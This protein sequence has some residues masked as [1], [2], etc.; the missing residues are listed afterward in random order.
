MRK[1]FESRQRP[2]WIPSYS[3]SQRIGTTS[4]RNCH[5]TWT[6][7]YYFFLHINSWSAGSVI[8]NRFVFVINMSF[9]VVVLKSWDLWNFAGVTSFHEI[10]TVRHLQFKL[11]TCKKYFICNYCKAT[12]WKWNSMFLGVFGAF[13]LQTLFKGQ[14]H[15]SIS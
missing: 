7:I 11:Q 2:C 13:L 12:Y 6:A 4:L 1:A 5:T 14:Q 9:L 15:S 10:Y 8:T 3:L